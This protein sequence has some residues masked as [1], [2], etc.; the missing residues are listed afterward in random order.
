MV[1]PDPIDEPA[2]SSK[3]MMQRR[4]RLFE[5]LLVACAV[6][7][8]AGLIP[9]LRVMLWLNLVSD[10]MLAGFIYF[11]LSDKKSRSAQTDEPVAQES[12]DYFDELYLRAGQ[13]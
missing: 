5:S 12:D 2:R 4:K 8:I 9:S 13:I 7:L 3:G 10:L 1:P 6:T 11:L